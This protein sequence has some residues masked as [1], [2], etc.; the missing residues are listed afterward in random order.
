MDVN[1][2]QEIINSEDII[3]VE[4]KGSAVWIDEVNLKN[5]TAIV[6]D[7]NFPQEQQTVPVH[8]LE[9]Q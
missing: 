4:W 5:G 7:E 2:A 9:E 8:E 6:H 1:R 3:H